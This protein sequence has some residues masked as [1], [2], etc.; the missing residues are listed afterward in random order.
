MNRREFFIILS[1][2]FFVFI[3]WIVSDIIHTKP[4]IPQDPK[5]PQVLEPVRPEFDTEALD[6]IK[7]ISLTIA[8][9][10]PLPT[11]SPSPTITPP[12]NTATP[13]PAT[14]SSTLSTP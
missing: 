4:S 7:N 9:P 1:I 13:P 14:Q 5:L 10:Q 11:P 2:T 3:L 6:L 12:I 8:S